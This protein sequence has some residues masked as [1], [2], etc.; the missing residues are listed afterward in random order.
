MLLHVG[1]DVEVAGHPAARRGLPLA[2]EADLVAVVDARRH[3][4]PQ[5][6]PPLDAP[7]ASGRS[8]Q[9]SST[10]W[11]VPRQRPQVVTLTIWPSMSS[12]PRAPHRCRCTVGQVFGLVPSAGAGARAGAAAVER[13][14]RDLLLAAADGL[15]ERQL[16]VVAQVR[17][18]RAAGSTRRATGRG[19]AEER[20]EDVAEALEA[21]N[22]P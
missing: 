12:A 3:R 2:G 21:P 6:P 4:H 14:E 20:V 7:V 16:E 5:G 10:I 13:G 9:A 17:P 1:H 8:W 11:P 19:A 15:V 18:G 22:G